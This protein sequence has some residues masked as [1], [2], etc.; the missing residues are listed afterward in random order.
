METMYSTIIYQL[1][2]AISCLLKKTDEIQ[3]GGTVSF[4]TRDLMQA[5]V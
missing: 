5:L 4:L 1:K 3:V 2:I